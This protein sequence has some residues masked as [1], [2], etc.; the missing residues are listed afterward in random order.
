M[1]KINLLIIVFLVSASTIFANSVTVS[2]AMQVA[3]NFYRQTNGT[4]ATLTL[5]YQC[6]NTDATNGVPIGQPMYYVFNAGGNN[7]FV[8]VSAE[9]MVMPVLAYNAQ[10]QFTM[11]NAPP[12]ITAWLDNYSQQIAYVKA[13]RTSATQTI[14]N[15]WNNYYNNVAQTGNQSRSGA[16]P[17]LTTTWDQGLYY[18]AMCPVDASSPVGFGGNVPTGCGATAMAQIMRYWSYPALGT[19]SNSYTSNYGTLSANFGATTY[20]WANMQN[21]VTS[22]N[23]D[24]ATLMYNCGVAVNMIYGANVS[25]SYITGSAPSCYSAYK[26]FFGYD[27]ATLQGMPRSNYSTTD[28]TTLI[29]TELNGGRPI[30]YAGSGASGGHTWVLDGYDGNGF[31]H[32]NWGWGGADNAYFSIDALD[33]GSEAFDASESMIIGIQPL[34]IV[35]ST[36]NIQLYSAITVNPNPIN[37][38]QTFTVNADLIN[39]GSAPYN[40]NYCAALFDAS[41]TFIRY[42]GPVLGTNGTPLP[43]GYDYTGGLTFSD[44]TTL[45]L[46]APGTYSIGI[47]YQ[48][49]GASTW[50][51]AGNTNYTNPISVTISGPID[52]ISLYTDMSASPTTFIQGQPASVTVNLTN[53]GTSIYYGQYEAVLLDLAGNFV[54][55]INTLTESNGLQS[56][57]HYNAPLTFNTG[58]VTASEGLYFLAIAQEQSGTSTWYYC[59]GQ[60]Y[61]NPVLINVVNPGINTGL[62]LTSVSTVK[63]Y[64]NPAS[65][66]ITID[67]GE[68][69]GNYSLKIF[70]VVGEVMSEGNG[71]LNGQYITLDVSKFA[72]GIYTLQLKTDAGN[73]T[74]KF[75]VE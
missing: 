13:N 18:N 67:A 54:E 74:T 49:A 21:S 69:Q 59:G 56:S 5:A 20:N 70:N 53:L 30:Q 12:V 68:A 75:T 14:S 55:Q 2:Y 36:A 46:T 62:S 32:M 41:G 71:A 63:V 52:D 15:Q 61:F 8:M 1:K 51:L 73:L 31:Y 35:P 33:P 22:S 16:G 65:N 44:A 45:A 23:A 48:P 6:L 7:G 29:Q 17:L 72:A 11:Q 47:Y 66:R 4:T 25:L 37:F 39:N 24:V 50:T 64:P 58:N 10:G 28:W 57:Y 60:T 38:D 43:V 19:G 9:D 27:P 3:Q 42:I 26:T 40:G 34:N